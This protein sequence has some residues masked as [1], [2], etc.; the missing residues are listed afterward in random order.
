[1]SSHATSSNAIPIPRRKTKV[2][3]TS[4]SLGSTS[5][6]SYGSYAP[7]TPSSSPQQS[8]GSVKKRR[9]SLMCT[10]PSLPL[11]PQPC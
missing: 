11:Y 9:E 8:S 4:D 7:N 10:L 3:A 2:H 1:M 5:S 6:E